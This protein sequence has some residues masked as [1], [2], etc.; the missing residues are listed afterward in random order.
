M[1]LAFA[2]FLLISQVSLKA[3]T[4]RASFLQDAGALHDTIQVLTNNGCAESVATIL[5]QAVRNYYAEPFDFDF[6]KFP[7]P[8]NGFYSFSSPRELIAA[9]PHRLPDTEH[10]FDLN[11]MDAVIMMATDRLQTRLHPDEIFGPFM[12]SITTT[13]GEAVTFAATP[14]DAFILNTSAWYRDATDAV[15]PATMHDSRICLTASL[16]RWHVLPLSTTGENLE[17]Q[18]LA[19][20]RTTWKRETVSFPAQFEVVLLHNVDLSHHTICTAHAGLL[21]HHKTGYTYVEKAGGSG[22]FVRLD[23][24]NKSDL[25]PW[26]ATAFIDYADTNATHFAT[27]ND[28]TIKKLNFK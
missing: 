24:D 18:V 9:L 22:P 23:F 13:N 4:I 2:A 11:C 28:S 8:L 12:M 26:L 3:G 1:K 15:L 6:G 25:L 5:Q 16:F 17:T 7:K 10:S 21:F 19:V 20:L 14:R 27:F